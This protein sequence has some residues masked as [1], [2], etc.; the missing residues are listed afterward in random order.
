MLT[1]WLEF[2]GSPV[3]NYIGED[4]RFF[5]ELNDIGDVLNS[6]HFERAQRAAFGSIIVSDDTLL[7]KFSVC[8]DIRPWCQ[9]RDSMNGKNNPEHGQ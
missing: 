1:T 5:V 4:F 9:R 7:R 6:S 8:Y 2:T 3:A